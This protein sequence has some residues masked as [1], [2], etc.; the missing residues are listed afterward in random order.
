MGIK[1]QMLN[2]LRGSEAQRIHFSFTGTTGITVS[3]DG[4]SFRRVAQAIQDNTI[5]IVE[6][7]VA[8]GRAKYSAWN[9]PAK[10]EAANTFYIGAGPSWSRAFDALLIHES[11]HASFD[12]TRASLPWLDNETAAYIAQGYYLRNSGF[13][14]E[15][16]DHVGQNNQP[17]LGR[18]IVAS[19]VNGEGIQG[20]WLDQLHGSLLSSP[21]YHDYINGDFTGDG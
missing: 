17:Y 3:V 10:G 12:L 2:V 5:H 11:V 13:S 6:S 7:G 8:A 4:S 1:E 9:N 19:I 20:F 16:L 15:R 18:Q 21:Q 14:S